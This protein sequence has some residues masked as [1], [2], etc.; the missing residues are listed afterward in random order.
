MLR[1][2]FLVNIC[3]KIILMFVI[4]FLPVCVFAQHNGDN[5]GFQGLS[6][7]ADI[8]VKATG[9]GGAFTSMTGD[10]DALF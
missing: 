5:I 4:V 6:N 7:K 10:L 9:M 3:K 8:G 1:I 2:K